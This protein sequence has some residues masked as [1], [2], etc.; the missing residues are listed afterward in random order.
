[1]RA[2]A[3]L[4][5]FAAAFGLAALWQSR[6]VEALKAER[7]LA[8]QI[9]DGEIGDSAS[10]LIEAGWGVVVVGAPSGVEPPAAAP[11]VDAGDPAVVDQPQPAPPAPGDALLGDFE[12]VVEAGQTLSKI[13]KAHYGSAARDLVGALARYNGLADENAL[14]AGQRLKLP[15]LDQLER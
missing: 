5:F 15:P 9:Q 1:M 13:A 6:R 11:E 10:G 14:R 2:V 12:L 8:A 3:L 7:R 4:L